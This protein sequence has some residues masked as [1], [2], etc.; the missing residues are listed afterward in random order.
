MGGTVRT[1]REPNPRAQVRR[2]AGPLTR[3][4]PCPARRRSSR[5][6]ALTPL[7]GRRL[8]DGTYRAA[9]RRSC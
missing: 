7:P 1:R 5:S 2:P 8:E 3:C 6:T 4:T 9:A